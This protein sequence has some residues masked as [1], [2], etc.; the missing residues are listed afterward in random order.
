[1]VKRFDL[2]QVPRLMWY[3]RFSIR[4]NFALSSLRQS[5]CRRHRPLNAYGLVSSLLLL[6]LLHLLS[7]IPT[8]ACFTVCSA[9]AEQR[10]RSI[11]VG[12]M[13]KLNE[14]ENR[15]DIS[16]DDTSIGDNGG[17]SGVVLEDLSWRVEK[18]RLEEQ[19]K[20]RFL[21]ARARFL[22]YEECRRWVQAWGK[23]WKTANDWNDWIAMGEKRNAYIPSRPDEYYGR[24]GQWVSWD[25]FL[26]IPPDEH[27]ES[28]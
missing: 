7:G 6:L 16:D 20:K 26:I 10:Q 14:N 15:E 18:L 19:N 22:P 4:R 9:S 8:A 28:N 13:N 25:H 5:A 23:R 17:V 12:K 21:K 2:I 3:N 24:L 11:V 1:M 27:E